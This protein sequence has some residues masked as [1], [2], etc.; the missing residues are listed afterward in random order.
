[1]YDVY[2][3][4]AGGPWFNSGADMWVTEWIKEVAPHLEVK[5]L[6]LFHR[7]RPDNYEEFPID[8]DHIWQ[9][10]ELDIDEILKGARNIHILHG[11]YTPTT[12][13][14]NNLD[15]INSIVFHNLTKVS[16]MS[17]M[18]KD[19]YLHWYG[20]WEWESELI[21]KI[22]NKVWVGLY[23]FPYKTEN[24]HHI[25]NTYQFTHNKELTNNTKIGFAARAEGR[26]NLE[27]ID[28]IDSYIS[29][30]SETF[31]KYYRKKYGYKFEKS[32]VYK[33]DHK[34]KERFYGL[35]WGISHSCFE[36]EPFGYGIF[37]AIDW[38]K[39]PIL[40]TK[41]VD[42]IDYKYKADSEKTF[43]KTYEMICKDD[44]ETRKVEFDKLKKWMMSNFSNKDV[45]KQKLLDIYNGD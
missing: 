21:D 33:F 31:N 36:N 3:T 13:I 6:L 32:K 18:N 29:T 7:K 28:G 26:K 44:Y 14:H 35:D 9:T 38:G 23:H 27:Y 25:P 37:E 43:K 42:L 34:H 24:L 39:L 19:E 17:Q 15:R 10:N 30:N 11:H 20:N 8:I 16:M 40:H 22:K 2:Y 5:P 4:T 41:W 12:A 45:W 1:M